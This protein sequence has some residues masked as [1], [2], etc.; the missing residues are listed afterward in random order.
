MNNN[1]Y[2]C[3]MDLNTYLGSIENA[4][5]LARKL[6]INPVLV[7]QWKNGYRAVPAER[8]PDIEVATG[9]KVRCEDL[10]PDVEWSVLRKRSK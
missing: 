2:C 5:S 7:S 6:G 1:C 8:C 10:R 9:G 3:D 4:A